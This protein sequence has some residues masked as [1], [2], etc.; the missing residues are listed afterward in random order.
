MKKIEKLTPEQVAKMAEWRDKWIKKGLNTDR[1]TK[2]EAQNFSNYLYEKI[3]KKQT[4]PVIVADSPLSAW[5]IV[6]LFAFAK[7]V[8]KPASVGDSVWASV[9]DSVSDSVRD[10]V[11]DSVGD[12]VW[13]SVSD[14]VS[15]SV[16]DSVSDSVWDSV[17]ASVS[18]SVWASVGDS[19][20]ASVSDSVWASVRDSVWDFKVMDF[21]YPF[22][23]GEMDADVIGFYDFFEKVLNIDYG[24]VKEN[25]EWWKSSTNFGLI[26]PLENVCVISQKP[27]EFNLVKNRLHADGK[28]ALQ[29]ADGFKIWALNGVRVPQYLAETP[30]SNLDIEFFKKEPNAD[31]KAE[32]IRKYGI[33]RMVSMGKLIDTWENHESTNN[34]NWYKKSEY[35]LIDMS[36]IFTTYDYLPYLKMRNQT[37]PEIYHLECVYNPNKTKQPTTILEGLEVRLGFN[38]ENMD[39]INIK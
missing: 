26:F 9:S 39:I 16:R 2:D 31:V 14:S 23:L 15:D 28:P 11:C 6:N 27:T 22:L 29:Y 4:V 30:A 18:D 24:K 25:W 33:E 35:K 10:S 38:P 7:K 20:W 36:P 21:F 3:L 19:V 5:I 34:F 13:A 17:R 12:S 32:F 8:Y 1:F 37:I